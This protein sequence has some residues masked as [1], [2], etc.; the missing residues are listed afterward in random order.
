M[1]KRC[2]VFAHS[3]AGAAPPR[4]PS[5]THGHI[6]TRDTAKSGMKRSRQVWPSCAR[7]PANDRATVPVRCTHTA[8]APAAPAPHRPLLRRFRACLSHSRRSDFKAPRPR[9]AAASRDR[10]T[11]HDRRVSRLDAQTSAILVELGSYF[12]CSDGTSKR[13]ASTCSPMASAAMLS[14]DRLRS[15]RSIDPM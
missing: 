14:I 9:S 10:A 7:V 3:S 12:S 8:S 11:P 5:S 4:C 2:T 15:E 13:Q 6:S 1:M